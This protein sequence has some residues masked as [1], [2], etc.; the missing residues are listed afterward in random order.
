[1]KIAVVI[2]ACEYPQFITEALDSVLNQT[3]SADFI[4][5]VIDGKNIGEYEHI[6]ED[7]SPR[8]LQC[9]IL[10]IVL[11]TNMGVSAA[12]NWG[13]DAAILQ[14]MDAIYLLD[15]DDL[16]TPYAIERMEHAAMLVPAAGIYY[17]DRSTFGLHVSYDQAPEFDPQLLQKGPYIISSVL[18]RREAWESVKDANGQGFDETLHEL[19]LR[20]EDYLFFLEALRCGVRFCHVGGMAMTRVR[21]HNNLGSEIANAT[22][23]RWRKYAEE[24][25][26]G[27]E[28]AS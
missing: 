7:Y 25:L 17:P 19:G 14:G 28:K 11:P 1:M 26:Y 4:I 23:D 12:R 9:C 20:W 27:K 3:R 22:V 10:K 6:L 15:E 2:P 18:L 5:V 13:I 24:K 16:L 21:I 8:S